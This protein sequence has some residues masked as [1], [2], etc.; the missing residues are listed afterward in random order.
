MQ[1]TSPDIQS[2]LDLASATEMVAEGERGTVF[3]PTDEA[4]A[5]LDGD[6]ALP[7]VVEVRARVGS[8]RLSSCLVRALQSWAVCYARGVA[9]HCTF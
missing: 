8:I 1:P 9:Q 7:G 4:F 5:L 2:L 3:A 6:E